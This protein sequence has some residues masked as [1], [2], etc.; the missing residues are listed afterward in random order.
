MSAIP[1]ASVS[2]KTMMDGT[3]RI[4]FDIEPM[5]AQ[6]AFK[7]FA[8]PGTPAAI[9]ALS[10][11]YMSKN[12]ANLDTSDKHVNKTPENDKPKGGALA[13]L[14]GMWCNDQEFWAWLETDPDN[15]CH[16]AQ[17]AAACLY[18]IC[19]IKSRAELDNDH[20]AAE[21]FHRLIRGPYQKHLIARGI[22]V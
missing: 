21:K 12:E 22:V 13:K 6:D 18:S 15:A 10:T 8:A 7:L 2:L 5:H 19:G 11:G 14:A 4:S 16:S 1:C 17:G 9:A 3:L 20:V